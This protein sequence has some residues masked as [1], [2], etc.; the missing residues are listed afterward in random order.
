MTTVSWT[1][2]MTQVGQGRA[3]GSFPT[4]TVPA[5]AAAPNA[6]AA[7]YTTKHRPLDKPLILMAGDIA[8]IWD[9]VSGSDT[10]RQAW[11]A[12]MQA[13]WPGALTL[14]L[15]AS[16]LVPTAM[17]P[18]QPGTIGV[19]VPNHG[20][21]RAILRHTGPLATT[22]ANLA[23][24]PALQD[25]AAIDQTFPNVLQLSDDALTAL[26]MPPDQCQSSGTASTIV[27]WQ[28]GDWQILRQGAVILPPTIR[29][30]APRS[31]Q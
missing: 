17:N 3:I 25:M 24:Q 22:S 26:A 5:L 15:P 27:Q 21:A 20:L 23:G 14:V 31:I 30:A 11:Q 12:L 29:Q 7:I 1:E 19:R 6:A 2:F 13:Y 28:Q 4:D 10:D 9:Y 8:T 18:L 16:P